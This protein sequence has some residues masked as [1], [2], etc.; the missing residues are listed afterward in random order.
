MKIQLFSSRY[1]HFNEEVKEIP[2]ELNLKNGESYCY[3]YEPI[4]P[5]EGKQDRKFGKWSNK[6]CCEDCK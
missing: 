2:I 4:C 6:Y 3:K 1:K 5:E